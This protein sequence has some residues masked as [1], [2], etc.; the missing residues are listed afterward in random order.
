MHPRS[1]DGM[2]QMPMHAKYDLKGSTVHRT[3]KEGEKVL[4]DNNV[5][6][7]KT[8]FKLGSQKEAFLKVRD[9]KPGRLCVMVD[10]RRKG[11]K[12]PLYIQN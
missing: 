1:I 12:R 4:K 3:S 11:T 2:A 6:A 7:A 10:R 9:G 8:T 5:R